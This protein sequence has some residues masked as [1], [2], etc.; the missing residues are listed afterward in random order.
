MI[1][2]RILIESFQFAIH[3]LTVNKLRTFLSLLGVT[4]GI[5]TMVSVF[6]VF[7]S[8]EN[9]IR[10][11][12]QD[13]GNNVIYVQKWPWGGG[14][15]EYPW[16]KYYQRPE[17]N[18]TEMEML[19]KRLDNAESVAFGFGVNQ[20]LNF[21][22]NSAEGVSVMCV[23]QDYINIWEYRF[24]K[25]RY[26]SE[27]ESR[28]GVPIVILGHDVAEGLFPAGDPIGKTIR[29]LGR[30]LR[31]I[32][33]LEKQGQSLVGNDVDGMAL[34]PVNYVRGLMSLKNQNGAVIMV[35]AKDGIEL[36]SLKDE[37]EGAMR[38][39]RRRK[40]K[41]END[42]A[43]NEISII[44]NNLDSLF[45]V[46]GMAG[47][48]IGGFSILVGGFG[49]ANIMFVSVKERTNQIGIQKS[50]GA[51]NYFIL[52]QFL[53]ESVVLC[54]LGG[55]VGILIVASLIPFFTD[56]MGFEL[57]LSAKN[58]SFGL[59]TAAVIGVISG[60]LPALMASRLN[61]VE[62]IRQGG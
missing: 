23:S 10:G 3:A 37:L 13:L 56:S 19:K 24:E 55:A 8:L 5:L 6:T 38:A 58:I 16:W 47:L 26:F 43:L 1:F 25:G 15:G 18:Y 22:R 31:V 62:A 12:V 46:V 44:S 20:T 21:G 4:I 30:K 54:V 2:L 35:K 28:N 29:I 9:S 42:F 45:G 53:L 34:V 36:A 11:S 39:I 27:V 52:L 17:P 61:P 60:F 7:D 49:I 48:V 51:K 14:D 50:L 33:V 59:L 40:P 32:G 57:V 41:A